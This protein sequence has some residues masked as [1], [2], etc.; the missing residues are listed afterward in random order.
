MTTRTHLPAT[1]RHRSGKQYTVERDSDHCELARGTRFTV[2]NIP[3]KRGDLC[4]FSLDGF[5]LPG[6]W[7]P[8]FEGSDWVLIPGYQI[9]ITGKI[10]F[11]ILGLIVPVETEV[12]QIT[13]MPE[14]EYGQFF[15]NP[16]PH[17]LAA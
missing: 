12:K 3:V 11:R 2:L 4:L 8:D 17:L 10:P 15:K 9:R 7:R 16:F 5:L 13:N 6:R 1:A 14:S